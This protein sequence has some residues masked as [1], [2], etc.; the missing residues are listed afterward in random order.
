M[1][2]NI[3]GPFG[4][5]NYATAGGVLNALCAEGVPLNTVEHVTV[6]FTG[7]HGGEIKDGDELFATFKVFP[8]MN[9]VLFMFRKHDYGQQTAMWG[10]DKKLHP[11]FKLCL[12]VHDQAGLIVRADRE[13]NLFTKE[14]YEFINEFMGANI[15]RIDEGSSDWMKRNHEMYKLRQACGAFFQGGHGGHDKEWLYIEF[16]KPEAAQAFVDYINEN[17][18]YEGVTQPPA[19]SMECY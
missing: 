11:K 8:A 6:S 16:W 3:S 7:N 18:V 5:Y 15:S 9:R 19:E 10:D 13:K 12:Y 14:L 4:N 2:T 1:T 17:F